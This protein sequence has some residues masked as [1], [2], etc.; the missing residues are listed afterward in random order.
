MRKTIILALMICWPMF[1]SALQVPG[2]Y[3]TI[4][5]AIDAGSDGTSIT[6]S[7]GIYA[8]NIHYKG[9]NI[10]LQSTDPTSAGCVAGT[11]IDGNDLDSVVTFAGTEGTTC[12]LNGFTITDGTGRINK[13]GG[14]HGN[15]TLASIQNCVI[16]ES[17]AS[18]T[19][20]AG[21]G[22][23]DCDGTI[24]GCTIWDNEAARS[25]G[26]LALCDGTI[27]TNT[28]T[29]NTALFGGGL[30]YCDGTIT[31]N[32][33][34]ENVAES[35][36]SWKGYGGGLYE[37]DGTINHNTIVYNRASRGGGL[38]KCNGTIKNS[39]IWW[40]QADTNAQL[41]GCVVPSYT[42]LMNYTGGTGCIQGDPLFTDYVM[43]DFSLTAS[44]P[45]R[46]AAEPYLYWDD[47]LT[48]PAWVT[49]QDDQGRYKRGDNQ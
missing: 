17:L 24:T 27:S 15:G 42:D 29:G 13:G 36:L 16:Y 7:A 39:I 1:A 47:S 10:T 48:T 38:S 43:G 32:T 44:S 26:G 14:I 19:Y 45:C 4:Q 2:D 46:D 28:I 9:K 35:T 20:G 11:V 49:V 34:A 37:C 21:G 30:A 5:G 18:G 41:D 6:I 12:V 25:G 40:N 3:S 22:I 8:E 31:I 23:R 33:I